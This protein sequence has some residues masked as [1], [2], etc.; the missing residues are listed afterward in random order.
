MELE[1]APYQPREIAPATFD[2]TLIDKLLKTDDVLLDFENDLR[3]RVYDEKINEFVVTGKV[4]MNDDGIRETLSFIR[5]FFNKVVLSSNYDKITI[6]K[7]CR[8]AMADYIDKLMIDSEKYNIEESD[9]QPLVVKV[10]EMMFSALSSAGEGGLRNLML[11]SV[12]ERRVFGMSEENKRTV[13]NMFG[14][15][16]K[17]PI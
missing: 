13:G 7:I 10:R 9:L 15:L 14:L 11:K 3:G 16:R 12:S 8:M 6:N 1:P 2:P 17:S 5:P 4:W